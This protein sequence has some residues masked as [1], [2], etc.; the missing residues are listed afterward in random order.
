[1]DHL[2]RC[3]R[4][5]SSSIEHQGCS[6]CLSSLGRNPE[7]F[8]EQ[9]SGGMIHTFLCKFDEMSF[10]PAMSEKYVLSENVIFSRL[11]QS[12]IRVIIKWFEGLV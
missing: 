3:V 9:Y 6:R 7:D 12:H 2:E 1:M 8:R 10:T 4:S 11:W 5:Q